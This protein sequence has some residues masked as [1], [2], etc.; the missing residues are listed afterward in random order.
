MEAAH[1]NGWGVVRGRFVP[2][3]PVLRED[4]GS[5]LARNCVVALL[6]LAR[7]VAAVVGFILVDRE[8]EEPELNLNGAGVVKPLFATLVRPAE[9]PVCSDFWAALLT[10]GFWL[11]L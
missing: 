2:V 4:A 1:L 7:S 3:T 10:T 11:G 9:L 6:A 8:D 5:G